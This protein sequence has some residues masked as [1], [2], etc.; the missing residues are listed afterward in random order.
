MS[1]P[2]ICGVLVAIVFLQYQQLGE[3]YQ[4]SILVSPVQE[5][6]QPITSFSD[7]I[8]KAAPSVVSINATSVNVESIERAAAD[9]VNLYLGERASLGSGVIISDQGSLI[10]N[11][12]AARIARINGGIGLNNR[13]GC[14]RI[15]G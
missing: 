6:K 3:L 8:S 13:Y 11:Q 14:I 5:A 10:I 9:R 12:G 7:A 15:G 1:W 4:Q 2:V